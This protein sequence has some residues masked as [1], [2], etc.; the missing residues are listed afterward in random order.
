MKQCACHDL[1]LLTMWGGGVCGSGRDGGWYCGSGA[2]CCAC[3]IG[4]GG[5]W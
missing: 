1:Q 4:G 5:P 2:A 3:G